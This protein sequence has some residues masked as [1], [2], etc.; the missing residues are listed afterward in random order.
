MDV[1]VCRAMHLAKRA[2]LMSTPIH[3]L[4]WQIRNIA[5]P[6]LLPIVRTVV[7]SHK[8]KLAFVGFYRSEAIKLRGA[9][10]NNTR[11]DI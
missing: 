9:V 7:A 8:R 6:L 5:H 10:W 1:G 2:A 4:V 11:A 3:D